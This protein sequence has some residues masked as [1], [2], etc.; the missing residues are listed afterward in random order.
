MCQ[1]LMNLFTRDNNSHLWK[2]SL[3]EEAFDP[4]ADLWYP[5]SMMIKHI[6]KESFLNRFT[7]DDF[8]FKSGA[9]DV[10]WGRGLRACLIN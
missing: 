8:Y 4:P 10:K 9:T 6:F 5:Q 7:I 3:P 2:V 1:M